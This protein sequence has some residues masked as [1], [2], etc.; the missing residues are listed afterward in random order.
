VEI[1]A[2]GGVA[3]AMACDI[4][5]EDSLRASVAAVTAR[6]GRLDIL[7]NNAALLDPAVYKQDTDIL[8]IPTEIWDRTMS[9]TLRGVMLGCRYGVLAMLETGGGSI[10]NTSSTFG[11]SAH[12]ELVAYGVAKAGVNRLTEYVATAFGR[13]GVR[14]NAVAPAL[15]QARGRAHYISTEIKDIHADSMLTPF[16]GEPED[17][18][19]IVAFLASDD[20]RYVTGQIIRA[21]GGTLAHLPTYADIRRIRERG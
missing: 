10:I 1:T 11:L 15:I 16:I 14:C 7:H 18:A 4:A 21:D 8:G 12:N 19:H 9:V 17:V 3:E 13:R 20:A 6:F 5:E 2:K